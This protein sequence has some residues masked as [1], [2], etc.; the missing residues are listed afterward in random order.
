MVMSN[1]LTN[2]VNRSQR[3]PVVLWRGRA[4][5]GYGEE[6]G[7]VLLHVDEEVVDAV[8]E[9]RDAPLVQRRV[10]EHAAQLDEEPEEVDGAV[11]RRHRLG[12]VL[13]HHVG[14]L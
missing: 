1:D 5:V 12:R 4:V 13:A 9:D 14:M 2:T 10:G 6:G 11:H 3:P 8:H 7:R